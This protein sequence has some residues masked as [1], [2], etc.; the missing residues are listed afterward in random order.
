MKKVKSIL[1]LALSATL[2][3]ALLCACGEPAA[4]GN[5]DVTIDL[6]ALWTNISALGDEDGALS[7]MAFIEVTDDDLAN[8]YDIDAAD[9]D[10][11]LAR[12]PMMNVSATEF[13]MA[14]V[15]D[16]KMDTVK[17]A[18]EAR[19]A[20]LVTTWSSYLPDQYDL[21]KNYKLVTN[22]SYV[23]FAV[24]KFADQAETLFNDAITAAKS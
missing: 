11:Y 4:S 3:L 17:A 18:L 13:F 21:V 15:K 2:L 24:S 9:L 6:N 23:F 14:K 19:Q 16:G 8:I 12:V 7:E 22:G 20:N 10:G 1:A 5:A